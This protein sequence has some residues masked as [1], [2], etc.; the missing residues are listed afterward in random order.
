LKKYI[1]KQ[2]DETISQK[3]IAVYLKKQ[4]YG[5]EIYN[6]HNLIGEL[7]LDLKIN[8]NYITH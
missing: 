4:L 1:L 6:N 5:N 2:M 7:L 3:I 8:P